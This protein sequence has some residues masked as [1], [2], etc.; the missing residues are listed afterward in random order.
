MSL[1]RKFDLKCS[2]CGTIVYDQ[3]WPVG[4]CPKCNATAYRIYSATTFIVKGGT[5]AYRG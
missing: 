3:E 4:A 1:T 2:I 5:G